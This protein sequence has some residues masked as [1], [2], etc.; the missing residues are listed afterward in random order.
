MQTKFYQ[1]L[2]I[3]FGVFVI[4]FFLQQNIFAQ[5]QKVNGKKVEKVK[6][7]LKD[8]KLSKALNEIEEL[9]QSDPYN[10][11]YNELKSSVLQQIIDK[12]KYAK[13]ETEE[14]VATSYINADN[15][16]VYDT[17]D[18]ENEADTAMLKFTKETQIE[19][20]PILQKDP[21]SVAA[22]AG[23]KKAT[24]KKKKKW[25]QFSEEGEEEATVFI[26]STLKKTGKFSE[27]T[28]G[29]GI[30]TSQL[31]ESA[32]SK[33]ENDGA[34]TGFSKKQSKAKIEAQKQQDIFTM[35]SQ[36]D[37]KFHINELIKHARK[38]T[39]YVQYADSSSRYLR[40]YELDT[41]RSK[42]IMKESAATFLE[43]GIDYLQNKELDMA[44]DNLMMAKNEDSTLL[45][46][47]LYLGTCLQMMG[48]DSMAEDY[49]NIAL[50]LDT[51]TPNTFWY[52]AQYNFK[53]GLY[54]DAL[55]C[56][57]GAMERY[58]EK[59]FFDMLKNIADKTAN[60]YNEQ[61]VPRM[62]FPILPSNKMEAL[63]AKDTTNPW[64]Y[65]QVAKM[66]Y[67]IYANP[68]GTMK[69]NEKTREPYLETACFKYMLDSATVNT[70]DLSFAKDM[71]MIGYLDAYCL[72]TLF[73]HDLYPQFANWRQRNPEKMRKYLYLVLNWGKH[74][75]DALKMYEKK[76]AAENTEKLKRK[77]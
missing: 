77:K 22:Y 34:P 73:H 38:A 13:G 15:Q 31:D 7:Y 66:E 49:F 27:S 54:D 45:D 59:V 9:I 67:A 58:P 24:N 16:V 28:N 47:Y 21:N 74:K 71:A 50:E 55:H 48:R 70:K 8:Y 57:V 53:K 61:W 19:V 6:S 36:M 42:K 17:V 14:T 10:S 72:V 65:Y 5:V 3:T 62:V 68:D 51:N 12:I 30:T 25:F 43:N 44:W 26:D 64:Y 37:E 35:L 52:L 11:Y 60:D 20:K 1:F 2:K 32:I 4:L 75:F 40:H 69:P 63:I 46:V 23:T 76:V 41:F 29:E 33:S 39:L 18:W 56:T